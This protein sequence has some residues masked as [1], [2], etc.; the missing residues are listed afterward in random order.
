MAQYYI[1]RISGEHNRR[2][3][4]TFGSFRYEAELQG[5]EKRVILDDYKKANKLSS[6]FSKKA[7]E[8]ADALKKKLGKA[9]KNFI[10][11]PDYYYSVV[12]VSKGS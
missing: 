10:V 12:T 2:F 9:G 3:L 7:N 1:Q 5:G 8:T 4:T 6:E 11:L